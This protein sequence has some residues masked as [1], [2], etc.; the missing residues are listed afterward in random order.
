MPTPTYTAL[1]N[2]TLAN[3]ASSVTFSS[4]PATYRDLVANVVILGLTSSPTTRDS[5][6]TLNGTGGSSAFMYA[7]GSGVSGNNSEILLPYGPYQNTTRLEIMDYSATDKHKTIIQRTG[8]ASNVDWAL[9]AR[10]PNTA[11]VTSIT[12][13]APD[14]G[15]RTFIAGST[16]ALY[17]IVA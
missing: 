8:S 17:G 16:F 13:N 2:V 5:Y 1:G 4:I 7:A 12:F 14:S 6:L 15:V 11:A 9:A 3:A 10:W